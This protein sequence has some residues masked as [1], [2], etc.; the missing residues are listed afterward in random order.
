MFSECTMQSMRMM[1]LLVLGCFAL[2]GV[3]AM[4][5]NTICAAKFPRERRQCVW[6]SFMTTVLIIGL[7]LGVT[8]L[9]NINRGRTMGTD[10]QILGNSYGGSYGTTYDPVY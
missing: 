3:A 7:V 10:P 4:Y 5:S 8:T 2:Y 9:Y 1:A 6:R